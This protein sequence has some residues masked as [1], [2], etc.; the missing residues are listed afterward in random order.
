MP[1]SRTCS[2]RSGS[3][4]HAT[5]V[6]FRAKLRVVISFTQ[7]VTQLES[8]YVLQYP[9]AFGAFVGGLG[10]V[11]VDLHEWVPSLR[12]SCLVGARS[13]SS[14]LLVATFVPLGVALAAPLIAA[15]RGKPLA[16]EPE[17][18]QSQAA[19]ITGLE[20]NVMSWGQFWNCKCKDITE[21]CV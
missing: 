5:R 7:I 2:R 8:V 19:A 1:R 3:R 16:I 4:A 14:Q 15:L 20:T 18:M 9:H 21:V 11:N 10:F 6:S 12:L 13:L 17:V